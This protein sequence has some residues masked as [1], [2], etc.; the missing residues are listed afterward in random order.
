[1]IIK[2]DDDRQDFSHFV[3]RKGLSLGACTHAYDKDA[4]INWI[5]FV[6]SLTYTA[7]DNFFLR[8]TLQQQLARDR[9]TKF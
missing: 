9:F 1:M 6:V 2:L 4:S 8:Y 3:F 7:E 5:E